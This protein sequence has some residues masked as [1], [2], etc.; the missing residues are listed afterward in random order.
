MKLF[1]NLIGSHKAPTAAKSRL[2]VIAGLEGLVKR[3]DREGEPK[4]SAVVAKHLEMCKKLLGEYDELAPSVAK[5]WEKPLQELAMQ[6]AV[7]LEKLLPKGVFKNTE[8]AASWVIENMP[9]PEARQAEA[10]N[11]FTYSQECKKLRDISN[12]LFSTFYKACS[13]ATGQTEG[14]NAGFA[15]SIMQNGFDRL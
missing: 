2:A 9:L 8:M 14:F 12:K 11:I 7:K 6:T 5:G 1:K 13:D 15:D 10:N 4:L 3:L